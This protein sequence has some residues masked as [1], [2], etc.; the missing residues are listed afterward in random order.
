MEKAKNLS[1]K[2]I[3]CL[4]VHPR[5]YTFYADLYAQMGAE[6]F[7][8]HHFYT[9]LEPDTKQKV[10]YNNAESFSKCHYPIKFCITNDDFDTV[11]AS[12]REG[13]D[14]ITFGRAIHTPDRDACRNWIQMIHG[15]SREV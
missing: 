13:A 7:F 4:S 12:I 3:F 9:V 11:S 1:I 10:R 14:W 8:T 5:E 15:T 6:Y 2:P